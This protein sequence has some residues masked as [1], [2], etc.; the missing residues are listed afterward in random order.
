MVAILEIGAFIS[1]LSVGRLG[2]IIGR[3]RTILYGSMVFLVGGALQTFANG[4]P[5]MLVGRI[6]AGLGVGALSTIVPVYQSEISPPHNRGKLACIEFTGNI[7]GYCASVWVD[8]FCTY[9]DGDWAWRLPLMMQCVMGAL[10]GLGSLLICE[11][12]RYSCRIR[13]PACK[14]LY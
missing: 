8:Y 3:R 1:S 12:P 7:C 4:M 2:D 14:D 6:M 10:L 9:I 5:M 13:A 11:S